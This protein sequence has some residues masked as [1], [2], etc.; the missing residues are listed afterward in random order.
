MPTTIGPF[1]NVPVPGDPIRSQWTQDISAYV[2][3]LGT[4]AARQGVALTQTGQI[5]TAGQVGTLNWDYRSNT[6]WGSGALLTAPA[7]TSGV[8]VVSVRIHGP[9]M[10]AGGFAD[11]MLRIS[12]ASYPNYIPQAKSDVAT[13]GMAELN[14]GSQIWVD[15]YNP[16]GSS[17]YYDGSM[18][19]ARVAI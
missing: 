11:I 9:Q 8:Y 18:L 1:T 13:T 2:A 10:P 3:K 6:S 17:Q 14:A 15:I 4:D 16:V 7:G 5:Y 12:G 19:I